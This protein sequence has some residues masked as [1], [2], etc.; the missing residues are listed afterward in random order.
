MEMCVMEEQHRAVWSTI[1]LAISS[2][3]GNVLS[4]EVAASHMQNA[5]MRA[6]LYPHPTVI[7]AVSTAL[8]KKDDLMAAIA[9]FVSNYIGKGSIRVEKEETILSPR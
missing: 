3:V 9:I 8:L 4:K 7:K 1:S 6:V 5:P 2:V